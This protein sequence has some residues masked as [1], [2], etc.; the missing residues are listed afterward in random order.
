[1]KALYVLA[2]ALLLLT[3]CKKHN[4]DATPVHPSPGDSKD[5][6]VQPNGNDSNDGKS[7]EKS[8]KTI[9]KAA[10]L[11][12]P[13][14]TIHLGGGVYEQQLDIRVSGTADSTI[15]FVGSF[16]SPVYIQQGGDNDAII[17][18]Q[19]QSHIRLYGLNVGTIT[20]NGAQGILVR[21]TAKGGVT[22]VGI[23][24]V[25]VSHV[26]WNSDGNKTPAA[27]DNAQGIIVYGEGTAQANA[28][29]NVRI[30]SCEVFDNWTGFS[31]AISFDGNVD[32]F[33]VTNTL[34]HDN[35]NIGIAMEGH[36]GTS[37]NAALDQARHGLISQ[38]TCHDNISTYATSGGIYVDG[39]A[40]IKV[41]RNWC[42]NNGYG[43]E[44]GCEEN[45]TASDITVVSNVLIQNKD[46]GL[47]I[48]GYDAGTSGQ[49]L[50]TYVINNT[51]YHNAMESSTSGEVAMSKASN[52][53]IAN[54]V[55]YGYG[56]LLLAV[57]AIT[58]QANNSFDYNCWYPSPTSLPGTTVSWGNTSYTSIAAYQ[59]GTQQDLHSVNADPLFTNIISGNTDFH[60]RT[61][62]PATGTGDI[63]VIKETSQL[64]MD[65]HSLIQAGHTNM[66][67]YQPQ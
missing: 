62:S 52:C 3:A 60:L 12:T 61:G 67:A 27:N 13:G 56:R 35:T 43:V 7:W 45:G 1:M 24:H 41:E 59:A 63:S 37:A 22:D 30:D 18:I 28:V 25:S 44:V 29:T 23:T 36:Y 51:F 14:T 66:G 65:G 10:D 33:Q 11:A 58:P 16:T 20:K 19:D 57:Q 42:W 55:F 17:T 32:G 31:E 6:Y 64:D 46:A 54:N 40:D 26:Q 38:N 2:A 49:V 15:N 34:V 4:D 8:F 39:A 50:N 21:A 48:G 5:Y 47:A 53:V 9:Q